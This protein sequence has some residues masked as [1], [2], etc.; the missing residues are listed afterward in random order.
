MARALDG[1]DSEFRLKKRVGEVTK[2]HKIV[3]VKNLTEAEKKLQDEKNYFE[4]I[5][6]RGVNQA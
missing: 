1:T 3:W 5:E 4:K 6:V 2:K